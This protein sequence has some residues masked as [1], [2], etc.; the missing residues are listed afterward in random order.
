MQ[1]EQQSHLEAQIDR[2]TS[3]SKLNRKIVVCRGIA[4][5]NVEI[6]DT[7]VRENID[8]TAPGAKCLLNM[9]YA[10]CLSH[11]PATLAMPG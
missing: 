6:I 2:I 7:N 11:T 5:V 3:L 9:L 4:N 10:N 8:L 1:L